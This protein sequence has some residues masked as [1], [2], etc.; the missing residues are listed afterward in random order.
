MSRPPFMEFFRRTLKTDSYAA[1]EVINVY[2]LRPVAAGIVWLLYPTQITPNQVTLIAVA[3]GFASAYAYLMGTA[4]AIAV[5]GALIVL[6]DLFDDADGQLA[7]AKEMYSRR[8]RFL[9]SIGDFLV[10]CLVFAAMTR[11]VYR[12]HSNATTIVLGALS[13]LGITLRVSYHVFYQASFLHLE[14]R[15]TLNRTTEEIR[16]E[17]LRGDPLTLRLQQIFQVIYGWQDRLMARIDRWCMGSDFDETHLPVWYSD[18]FGLRLSGFL[19]FGTELM[20]LG[21]CSWFDA[22][23]GYLL[24][25]VFVMNGIWAASI[26]YRRL[27][28]S[29][30][31]P[32]RR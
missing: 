11:T 27:V 7:R 29:P 16:Q 9:D 19:G 18:R 12:T 15:Y 25:N 22:I 21:L 1:D 30:N 23:D 26:M 17:D 14:D 3:F 24:L 6:K 32:R 28:L 20:L 10:D 31:L 2:L 8:G 4:G 13:L 5:A